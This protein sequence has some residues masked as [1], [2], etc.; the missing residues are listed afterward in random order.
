MCVLLCGLIKLKNVIASSLEGVNDKLHALPVWSF[1]YGVIDDRNYW[2]ENNVPKFEI[3]YQYTMGHMLKSPFQSP[4]FVNEYKQKC[5]ICGKVISVVDLKRNVLEEKK[6]G[7]DCRIVYVGCDPL[8]TEVISC[9][10]CYYSNHYLKFFG[11]NNFE[12]ELVKDLLYK[13]HRPIVELRLDKRG[14]YDKMAIKYLQAININEHINPG[15]HAL[16]G[17]LWRNLY[18]L[19]RRRRSSKAYKY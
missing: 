17:S 2:R 18:W 14:D 16:I 5:P 7:S 4:Q 11:I 12:Y 1:C 13:Q 9:P 8:W 19:S 10:H 3:P 6:F 15:D